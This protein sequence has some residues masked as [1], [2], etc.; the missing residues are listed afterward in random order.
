MTMRSRRISSWC[1]LMALISPLLWQAAAASQDRAETV[2]RRVMASLALVISD[3]GSGTA[4]CFWSTSQK[5]YFLTDYHVVEGAREVRLLLERERS[6]LGRFPR[7]TPGRVFPVPHLS[8][9]PDLAVVVIDVGGVPP[10]PIEGGQPPIGRSIGLLG[11]PAVRL[12]VATNLSQV[13]PSV[14]YG[15]VNDG[16][17]WVRDREFGQLFLFEHDAVSDHGNSGGPIFDS[18]TGAVLGIDEEGLPG[19][20]VTA[21]FAQPAAA[22]TKFLNASYLP[23]WEHGPTAPRAFV[24]CD[25]AR[26]RSSTWCTLA[27]AYPPP[28]LI[29]SPLTPQP[30]NMRPTAPLGP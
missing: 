2:T 30:P 15:H 7:A 6:A 13:T 12:N 4:F 25:S 1:A 19:Q 27:D 8:P 21:N 5:S 9:R 16:G 18:G 17:E 28:S 14:H 26:T 24:P 20:D 23:T 11:Y 3:G 29:Y 22:I 10:L